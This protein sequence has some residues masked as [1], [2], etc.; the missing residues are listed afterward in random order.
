MLVMLEQAHFTT[1]KVKKWRMETQNECITKLKTLIYR[2][3]DLTLS[4]YAHTIFLATMT[5][6]SVFLI[7]V[8]WMLFQPPRF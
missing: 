8:M 5:N 6:K 4:T 7:V 1:K 2:G 3:D